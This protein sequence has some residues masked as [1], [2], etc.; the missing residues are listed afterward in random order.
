M[1]RR[2]VYRD[3]LTTLS[4]ASYF[5]QK[6]LFEIKNLQ[7]SACTMS[8]GPARSNVLIHVLTPHTSPHFLLVQ[9]T[10]LSHQALIQLLSP[11]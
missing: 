3:T 10:K 2:K 11:K 1:M 5:A 4:E 7:P 9:A 8:S 6:S